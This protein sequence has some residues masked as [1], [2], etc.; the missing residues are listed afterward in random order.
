MEYPAEGIEASSV[1]LDSASHVGFEISGTGETAQKD[2]SQLS[3]HGTV[4][5]QDAELEVVVRPPEEGKS[6]PTLTPGQKYTFVS[7]TRDALGHVCQRARRR[8]RN[9]DEIRRSLQPA[10]QT[11]QITYN[12]SGGTETVTG[13]VEEAKPSRKPK[14][15]K[16]PKNARKPKNVKKPK[17]DKKRK[18]ARKPKKNRKRKNARKRT[19]GKDQRSRSQEKPRSGCSARREASGRRSNYQERERRSGG[20][21][22]GR[23]RKRSHRQCVARRVQ[24]HR[25]EQR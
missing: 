16:K 3:A 10:S 20:Q 21:E 22:K 2:Y 14:K 23:R 5:L 24:H 17:K 1:K 15:N 19:K 6:C 8:R 25:S 9:T 12:R 18:N 4:E 11:M 7:T 13:T